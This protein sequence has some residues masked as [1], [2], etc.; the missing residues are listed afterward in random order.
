MEQKKNNKIK[1]GIDINEVI[2]ARW[3]QFDKY[4]VEEF[5]EEG[6]PDE[7]QYVYDF[8]KGYKWEDTT[9]ETKYLKE[10]LPDDINPLDYQ[11]D[12]ET[13]EA[14]VDHLAF[15]TE[16]ENLTAKEV[17]NRFMYQDYVFEIHGAAPVMYKQLDLHLEKFYLKYHKHVDFTILSQENWFSVP[18]TLFFLSRIMSRFKKYRFVENKNEMWDEVDVLITTDPDII[19]GKIPEGKKVIKL[20]RPYNKDSQAGAIDEKLLQVNDLN[21]NEKFEKIIN[22]NTKKEKKD[23]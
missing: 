8:F 9:E 2:R 1:V 14:P 3:L 6:V 23:E 22:Y 13:G 5:G 21:G 18:P 7:E 16:K 11:V 15:K 19:D 17:F 12:E 20:E 10:D 4:Y